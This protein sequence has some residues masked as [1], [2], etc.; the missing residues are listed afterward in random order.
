MKLL[1]T[2]KSSDW[3]NILEQSVQLDYAQIPNG[4]VYYETDEDGKERKRMRTDKHLA[5]G[6][7]TEIGRGK[8]VQ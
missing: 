8:G 7:Q 5:L 4:E 2:E 3:R 1:K 6:F